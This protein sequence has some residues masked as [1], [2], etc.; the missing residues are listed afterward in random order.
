MKS[1]KNRIEQTVMTTLFFLLLGLSGSVYCQEI[2]INQTFSSDTIIS[3]FESGTTVYSIKVTGS[4]TLIS[5]SSL[6][7]IIVVDHAGNHFLL[8]EAY[9]LI[10][11]ANTFSFAAACDE[12]CFL[13]GIYPDSIRIDIINALVSLDTL[14]YS[15]DEISNA[16]K[17]QAGE[18]AKIDSMKVKIMNRRI[19]EENM[20]WRA[21]KT[22]IS[23]LAYQEKENL[24]TKKF[25]LEGFDYYIGGIYHRSS[26][27]R[28]NPSPSNYVDFD[29]RNRHN[30]DIPP[31][32]NNP[33]PY[34]NDNGVGW[35]TK[36]TYNQSGN[37]C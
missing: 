3:P 28:L 14:I 18:K 30:S 6:A 25:N 11:T 10:D 2:V 9:P 37:T 23:N 26:L 33:S 1:I 22:N 20:Y 16:E 35:V 12:T 15:R 34:Y 27:H 13:D 36:K 31:Q 5:D 4:I 29:W 21:G 19:V 8:Y 17:L 32:N 24:Y 7:R